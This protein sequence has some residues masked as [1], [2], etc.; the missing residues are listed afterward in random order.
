MHP[1]AIPM[2]AM[3]VPVMMMACDEQ[4]SLAIAGNQCGHGRPGEIEHEPGR[5]HDPHE[6][7]CYDQPAMEKRHLHPCFPTT[8]NGR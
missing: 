2:V 5:D 3:V 6:Q 7:R 4:R 8:S 1:V